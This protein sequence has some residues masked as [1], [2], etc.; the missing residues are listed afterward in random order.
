REIMELH[1]L[2]VHGGYTQGDVTSLAHLL[3]GWT[4]AREGDGMS[5]GEMRGWSFAYDPALSEGRATRGVGGDF[6]GASPG[7]GYGRVRFALEV[8]A[9]HPST[10]HFVCRKL[11]E[12]YVSAPAPESLVNDLAARFTETGGDMAEVL[13]ALA[14]HPEFTRAD[15]PERLAHPMEY[16]LR[17][18]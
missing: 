4:T 7:E 1:T 17:L 9:A 18:A 2:G 16:A 13:L 14:Q 15:L 5:G 11:A 12:H 8:L 10:A 6:A 3:T